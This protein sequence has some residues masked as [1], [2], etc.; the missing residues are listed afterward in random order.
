MHGNTAR[1]GK[2]AFLLT[3]QGSQRLGMGRELYAASPVFAAAFDAVCAQLDLE[4]FRS[5]KEVVFAPEDSA[6]SAL[7]GQTV[8]TQAALFALETA[9]FRLFEHHGITPTTS[10]ATRSGKSPPPT[11]PV[12]STWRTPASSSPSAAG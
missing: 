11:W 8:M 5:V 2:L 12:C 6:D 4:L 7:L 1:R 3:G 10:S 9:L